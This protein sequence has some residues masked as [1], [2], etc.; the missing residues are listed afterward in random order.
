MIPDQF[1]NEEDSGDT[2]NVAMT[3]G[4]AFIAY[5]AASVSLYIETGSAQAGMGLPL[6]LALGALLVGV[7]I[8]RTYYNSENNSA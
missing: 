6:I 1:T 4:Y 3:L 5:I 2:M 7:V 8:E